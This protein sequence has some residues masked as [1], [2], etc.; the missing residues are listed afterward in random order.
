MGSLI[1]VVMVRIGKENW[2]EKDRVLMFVDNLTVLGESG[3]E[4]QEQ[5]NEWVML[6]GNEV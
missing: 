5:L 4:V 6:N 3:A 2:E 1:G